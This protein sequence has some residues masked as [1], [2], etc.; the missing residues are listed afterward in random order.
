MS[1]DGKRRVPHR[2]LVVQPAPVGRGYA[3]R[4]DAQV[5]RAAEVDGGRQLVTRLLRVPGA[6]QAQD[7]GYRER[8]AVGV[9]RPTPNVYEYVTKVS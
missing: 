4:V 8:L 7:G 5:D 3:R 9:L 1:A 6:I 2:H